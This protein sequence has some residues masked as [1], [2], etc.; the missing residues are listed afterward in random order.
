MAEAGQHDLQPSSL[1]Q[2]VLHPTFISTSL[3]SLSFQPAN[4]MPRKL[5]KTAA[6]IRSHYPEAIRTP[7]T[8]R[9]HVCQESQDT[10]KLTGKRTEGLTLQA[11]TYY[12]VCGLQNFQALS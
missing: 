8:L 7:Q 5:L 1:L 3:C 10:G 12:D 11:H 4:H 6:I 2:L 9:R